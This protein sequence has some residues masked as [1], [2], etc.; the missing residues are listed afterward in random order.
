MR[1]AVL[2]TRKSQAQRTKEAVV[3]LRQIE[4]PQADAFPIDHRPWGY[5]ESLARG[6]RF[7]VKR[8]VVKPGAALSLQ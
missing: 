4:A 7:Q 1:D 3:A 5:F 2:V 8:I 6:G